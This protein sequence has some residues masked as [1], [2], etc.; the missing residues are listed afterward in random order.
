MRGRFVVAS[1][2]G[3]NDMK[4][5]SVWCC[6]IV[7]AAAAFSC[8]RERPM[9]SAP[10]LPPTPA[11]TGNPN[12][13]TEMES[14][15]KSL[16]AAEFARRRIFS[17]EA[18]EAGSEVMKLVASVVGGLSFHPDYNAMAAAYPAVVNQVFRDLPVQLVRDLVPYAWRPL[19]DLADR[20]RPVAAT[21]VDASGNRMSYVAGFSI[22]PGEFESRLRQGTFGKFQKAPWGGWIV[23]QGERGKVYFLVEEKFLF[24]SGDAAL[25]KPG[26][27]F[28]QERFAAVSPQKPVSFHLHNVAAN[29]Q[30][31]M[32]WFTGE[33]RFSNA[34]R[35][36][37]A[38]LFL[39]ELSSLEEISFHVGLDTDLALQMSVSAVPVANPMGPM[40]AQMLTPADVADLAR[41][42]PASTAA[43]SLDKLAIPAISALYRDLRRELQKEITASSGRDE[44]KVLAYFDS[45]LEWLDR[46]YERSA[47]SQAFFVALPK[48]KLHLGAFLQLR[49]QTS[50]K[51][52]L[53]E[54]DKWFKS[55]NPRSFVP[56]LS[57]EGKKELA[58]LPKFLDVRTQMATVEKRSALVVKIALDWNRMPREMRDEDSIL[59]Q[60]FLGKGVELAFVADNDSLWFLA[61]AQW[62]DL[63][64]EVVARGGRIPNPRMASAGIL[65][66]G[67]MDMRAFVLYGIDEFL[68]I[69]FVSAL[70]SEMLGTLKAARAA[71]EK[72]GYAWMSVSAGRLDGN[73]I[74]MR[75]TLERETWPIWFTWMVMMKAMY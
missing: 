71:F 13:P 3:N 1:K 16:D 67:A 25:L 52:V 38:Q 5:L 29:A 19:L 20:S 70:D 44:A 34:A 56:T 47:D 66:T 32:D 50:G 11:G 6:V 58:W 45:M 10:N 69:K 73:R 23:P 27:A 40:V 48:G 39:P 24:L 4:R 41:I 49:P 54:L 46:M 64:R 18:G 59:F 17:L 36:K 28:L 30:R 42:L 12:P 15:P 62:K 63:L 65:A 9:K 75:V 2:G 57:P 26:A 51:D 74:G 37:F 68:Q 43:F 31:Y 22:D 21:I 60:H 14:A 7:F 72:F 8:T 55:V 61:G 53:S 33:L 35:V